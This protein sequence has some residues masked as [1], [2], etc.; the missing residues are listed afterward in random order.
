[1]IHLSDDGETTTRFLRILM[2]TNRDC[3]TWKRKLF[4]SQS[5]KEEDVTTANEK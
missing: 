2:E 3:D 4:S 5:E 1:M